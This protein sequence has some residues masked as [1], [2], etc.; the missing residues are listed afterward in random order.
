MKALEYWQSRS[1][2]KSD[3]SPSEYLS[4]TE[5]SLFL[6][7]IFKKHVPIKS[8]ILELGCNS[9]RNLIHLHKLGYENISGVDINQEAISMCPD[10]IKTVCKPL[11]TFVTDMDKYD[12]IFTMATFEH[13]PTE[14]EFVFSKVA[15]KTKLLITI[16][17]EFSSSDYHFPR[18]YKEVFKNLKQIDY[19]LK[20]PGQT[21]NF[22]GRVFK[23][24]K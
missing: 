1:N 20:V 23:C 9:G 22:R 18:N 14:S 17:D 6:D 11:E 21:P 4:F 5:R 7:K 8:S 10:F 24:E 12:V 2:S 3:N 13:L 15:K 16:E 19:F